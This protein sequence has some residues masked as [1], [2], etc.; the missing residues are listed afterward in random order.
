MSVTVVIVPSV[1]DKMTVAPPVV[2]L[3]PLA[4]FAWIV[5]REVLTPSAVMDVGDA[6]MVVAAVL[7]EPDTKLTVALSVIA[8]LFNV[9]VM[10]AIATVVPDVSV[11]E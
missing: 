3:L 11:A 9:A 2:R 5:I 7:A 10:V 4:S 1:V 6:V 8:V